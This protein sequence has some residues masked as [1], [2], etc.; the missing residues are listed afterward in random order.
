MLN[1]KITRVRLKEFI[2][3]QSSQDKTL[4]IGCGDRYYDEFFPNKISIDFDPDRHPDLVADAHHLPFADNE[5]SVVLCAEVLEHLSDPPQAIAEMRRVLKPGG[6][7]ILTTRFIFPIHDAPG[8]YYRFTE[9][10][11]RQLFKD[12]Q[13]STLTPE[14]TDL[15]T[16]AV[17]LQRLIYQADYRANKLVKLFLFVLMK[18]FLFSAGLKKQF[19]GNIEKTKPASHILASGYYL[20]AIKN[21]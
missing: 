3:S 20:V 8:D 19:Y 2:K 1:R 10:G 12:W 7:L 16:V 11:L 14:T 18:L 5:F 13:L 9:Y 6:K 4:E 21:N 15:S 17:I